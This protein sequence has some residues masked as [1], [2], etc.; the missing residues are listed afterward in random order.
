MGECELV[1]LIYGEYFMDSYSTEY[2]WRSITGSREEWK[3]NDGTILP[4]LVKEH[5][6]VDF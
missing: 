6:D 2:K 3:Q 1:S 4:I 5:L